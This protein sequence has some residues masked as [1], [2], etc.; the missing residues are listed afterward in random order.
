MAVFHHLKGNYREDRARV[1]QRYTAKQ[2]E[3]KITSSNMG[4]M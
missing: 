3:G 4:K 2:Q 1:S